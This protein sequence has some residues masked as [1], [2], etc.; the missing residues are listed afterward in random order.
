MRLKASPVYP[1]TIQTMRTPSATAKAPAKR[2]VDSG[3]WDAASK[4]FR[5]NRG[6]TA[7][8]SPS[9]TKTRPMAT[10]RWSM[11]A[12]AGYGE[13]GAALELAPLGPASF[14]AGACAPRAV[15]AGWPVASLK[16]WKNWESGLSSIRVSPDANAP[17]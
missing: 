10:A 8:T 1:R 6:R 7:Q 2:K 4:S 17:R 5:P 3:V 13:D 11:R 16:N 14:A 15:P 9:I 12:D